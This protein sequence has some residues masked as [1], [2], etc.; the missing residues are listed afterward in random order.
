MVIVAADQHEPVPLV[1]DP[2]AGRLLPAI[3]RVA[4]ALSR[5]SPA[6]GVLMSAT[7]KTMAGG[8]ASILCRKRYIDDQLRA[9]LADGVDAVVILGAG[10]DTRAYRMP[11]L[12]DVAVCE[13]DLPRNSAGKAAALRRTLGAPPVGVTL[14][15]VDFETDDLAT[16]LERAGFG[17]RRRTCYIWEA[18]TQ[19]LTEPSVRKTMECLSMAATGS[20]LIFTFVRDDFLTGQTMYGA[21]SAYRRFVVKTPAKTPAKTPLWR[22][23]LAPEQVGA[24]LADYGWQQ[25][26]QVG[27]SQ[28]LQRYLRPA[29]RRAAVSEIERAVLAERVG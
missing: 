22:F 4:A 14:L 3:G 13:V 18:V 7:E 8:W 24:F 16:C 21:Q 2:Y 26:E 5:W 19:Y 12:A 25:V 23:G 17:R 20:R 11:E 15:P 9:A 28:Y 27:P 6:R 29:G 10:Y 1:L